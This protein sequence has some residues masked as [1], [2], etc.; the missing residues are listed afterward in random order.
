MT[1]PTENKSNECQ[2]H[3]A[4]AECDECKEI[5]VSEGGGR[6]RKCECGE[7]YIDQERQSA[8][9]VRLGGKAKLIK[10]ICHKFCDNDN[11]KQNHG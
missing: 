1:K 3:Y 9:F 8:Y 2:V 4:L 5:I 10:Q 6:F 11:H 7:S